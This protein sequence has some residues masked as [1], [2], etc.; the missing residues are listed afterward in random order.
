MILN[1]I[2]VICVD[3][4]EV[5]ITIPTVTH[6]ISIHVRIILIIPNHAN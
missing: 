5:I 4:W 3:D 2:P 1:V 6:T